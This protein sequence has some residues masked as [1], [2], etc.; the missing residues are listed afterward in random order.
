MSHVSRRAVL[1][2]LTGAVLGARPVVAQSTS[3][4]R[5][6]SP[7]RQIAGTYRRS[8]MSVDGQFLCL[9]ELGHLSWMDLSPKGYKEVSRAQLFVARESWALPVLSRGLL[10]V[11]QN[12]RDFMSGTQPRLRCYDLRA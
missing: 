9:G 10:Y 12:T 4:Q 2:G 6:V 5:L 8:L 1:M 3:R 7:P 11:V